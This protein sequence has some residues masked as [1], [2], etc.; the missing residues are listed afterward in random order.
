M[1]GWVPSICRL[2]FDL[3]MQICGMLT[4]LPKSLKS[5]KTQLQ[6]LSPLEFLLRLGLVFFKVSI[7]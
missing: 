2:V 1:K 4:V 6:I 5:G 7:G 3:L